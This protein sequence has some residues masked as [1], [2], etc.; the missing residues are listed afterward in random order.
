[1]ILIGRGLD[2]GE[3]LVWK[4]KPVRRKRS[5]EKSGERALVRREGS[6]S[7]CGFEGAEAIADAEMAEGSREAIRRPNRRRQ[8]SGSNG[9]QARPGARHENAK[10]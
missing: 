10:A 2:L 4:R 6:S 1:M 7:L 8:K 5:F 9:I 3:E